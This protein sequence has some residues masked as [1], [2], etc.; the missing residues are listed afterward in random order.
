MFK[1]SNILKAIVVF[2]VVFV[3]VFSCQ[4]QT[5][6]I[7]PED[8]QET[9]NIVTGTPIEGQYIVVYKKGTMSSSR[10]SLEY[11]V[12]QDYMTQKTTEFLRDINV[13]PAVI[14]NV[15]GNALEGFS[16]KLSEERLNIIR[17][18][19]RVAYVEQD[20]FIVLAPG[21]GRG[22]PGGDGGTPPPQETPWGIA[23]VNGGVSGVGLTAWIIDS[24]IDLD[25]PDLNVDVARS[26]SYVRGD[27]DDQN[28]HGTHVSGTIAAIDNTE[29]VIGVAAGATVVAVRVLDRRGSGSTS[30]VIAGVDYVGANGSSGDVANM[31]LGGG[32]SQALDD[33]VVNASNASGVIFCLAAGNSSD[34]AN[35]YSPARVN[36]PNIITVSASDINDNFAS[37]SNW[38]NPPIDWCAPGVSVKST[39]KDAGYNTI[40]GTSMATPHVA[41]VLLLGAGKNG[42]SVNG[43]P[44][45]NPDTIITH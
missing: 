44:D 45:G 39:W 42:G 9:T 30:G 13:D 6:I 29:G 36:G 43:D 19:P 8:I 1:L 35:N 2:G 40:S 4:T 11:K 14:K 15:Y 12:R 32:V 18:D 27:A 21:G 20:K 3:L 5:E 23:R 34:D 22:K 28:G 10:I 17:N 7:G 26:V 24:G 25:H 31:S 41:G 33:A 16:A 37:F 38:G